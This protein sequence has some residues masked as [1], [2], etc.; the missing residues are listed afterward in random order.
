L[1]APRIPE[2][3]LLRLKISDTDSAASLP[4]MTKGF[5]TICDAGST[6]PRHPDALQFLLAMSAFTL[7]F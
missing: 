5:R 7:Q 4:I 1:E 2:A 6:F 3:A